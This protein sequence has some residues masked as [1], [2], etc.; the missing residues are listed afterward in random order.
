MIL[1]P[2]SVDAPQYRIP[3]VTALLV[4]VNVAVFG[5]IAWR[6]DM[7][8]DSWATTRCATWIYVLTGNDPVARQLWLPWALVPAQVL[9]FTGA[10]PNAPPPWVTMF[11]HMFLHRDVL[12][13]FGNML[14]LWVYGSK[15]EGVLG[16][17]RFLLLYILCGLAAALAQAAVVPRSPIPMLGASGAVAGI[18]AAFWVLYPGAYVRMFFWFI[19]N[20]LVN[21]THVLRVPA[22]WW[23]VFWLVLQ[24]VSA[25]LAD[26]R[27]GGVAWF[28]H[29]GGFGTGLFLLFIAFPGWR[30]ARQEWIRY[31][32][33]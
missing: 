16:S 31:G 19:F 2:L 29:L 5:Y 18:L 13:L 11:T 26:P 3:G 17:L 15:V 20:F 21:M 27:R 4:A 1:L 23:I 6:V 14:F 24:I 33:R 7:V 12:H 32:S 10:P 28:A 8:C 30:A 25:A 9:G 22:S